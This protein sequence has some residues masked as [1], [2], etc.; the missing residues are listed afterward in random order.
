M[1]GYST[2]SH[3]FKLSRQSL[4][5]ILQLYHSDPFWVIS[6]WSRFLVAPAISWDFSTSSWRKL[7]F[8]KAYVICHFSSRAWFSASMAQPLPNMVAIIFSMSWRQA[9]ASL[10]YYLAATLILW[11]FST[12]F[13]ERSPHYPISFMLGNELRDGVWIGL[14]CGKSSSMTM[15][16]FGSRMWAVTSA[17]TTTVTLTWL[18]LQFDMPFSFLAHALHCFDSWSHYLSVETKTWVY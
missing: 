9:K 15:S 2:F 7:S 11:N 13:L 10:K 3:F 5:L 6:S 4:V 1:W 17:T 18:V 12:K 8:F 16:S 14:E